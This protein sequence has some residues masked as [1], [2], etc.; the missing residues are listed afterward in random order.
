[1]SE[2]A[3]MVSVVMIT[4]GHEHF[5]EEAIDS[6]LMQECEFDFELI[7]ADDKSPDNTQAVVENLLGKHPNAE[8]VRYHR[9]EENMGVTANF[10][11]TLEEASGKYLAFCEGDD[12]W[13]DPKKLQKQ[14]DFLEEHPEFVLSF[15][16]SIK[17]DEKSKVLDEP[18]VFS[19]KNRSA[20]ELKGGAFVPI[21]NM[22]YRTE[23]FTIP[24]E[25]QSARL[26]DIFLA[27]MLGQH[28]DAY[29]DDSIVPSAYRIHS[30]GIWS[31][32]DELKRAEMNYENS[33]LI[34]NYFERIDAPI[35]EKWRET[36]HKTMTQLVNLHIS[37]SGKRTARKF[38]R[39]ERKNILH[40]SSSKA[41]F[42][43]IKHTFK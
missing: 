6:I 43:F 11:F 5:I 2:N 40:F 12:F 4:Y 33:L 9:H 32:K 16:D 31:S 18:E 10:N 22:L 15:H 27:S 7:I 38:I 36:L 21:R 17:V 1:M 19:K 39:S 37:N 3:P 8:K 42:R 41:Y 14:V 24:K 25:M 13:R 30:G 23:N 34:L 28:G 35:Q 29:F 26:P 20:K